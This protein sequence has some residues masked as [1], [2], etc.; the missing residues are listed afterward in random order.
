MAG[1]SKVQISL[2]HKPSLLK[3]LNEQQLHGLAKR[4][5]P[6]QHAPNIVC[7]TLRN[8]KHTT[9][10][11]NQIMVL[12][13][14]NTRHRNKT[15]EQITASNADSPNCP[16]LYNRGNCIGCHNFHLK[17]KVEEDEYEGYNIYPELT[18]TP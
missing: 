2:I 16:Y 13:S 1:Q 6:C 5:E 8:R 3:E 4:T 7:T 11:R 14:K 12:V 17:K 15:I 10:S 18:K 9:Q